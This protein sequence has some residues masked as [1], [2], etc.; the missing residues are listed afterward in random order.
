MHDDQINSAPHPLIVTYHHYNSANDNNAALTQYLTEEQLQH[1]HKLKANKARASY[2]SSRALLNASLQHYLELDVNDIKIQCNAHG[3]PYI[4]SPKDCAWTFNLSHTANLSI[5]IL[6]KRLEVGIDI[7]D[8]SRKGNHLDI[9]QRFFC[10]SEYD[11]LKNLSDATAQQE[12]FFKLWTFKEA[13]LKAHGTG[14]AQSLNSV[15]AEIDTTNDTL[16]ITSHIPTSYSHVLYSQFSLEK[17]LCCITAL[18][19]KAL[20]GILY[21]YEYNSNTNAFTERSLPHDAQP[22]IARL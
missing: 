5:I 3:K 8:P 19:T 20:S 2:L 16:R 15:S 22:K 18:N 21:L 4:A 10:T 1:L 13:Y 12:Y 6:N 7:E 11:T 17:H 14:L 9:A